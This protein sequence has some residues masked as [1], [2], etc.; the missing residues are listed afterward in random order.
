MPTEAPDAYLAPYR[1]AHEGHGSSFGVTLWASPRSQRRRFEVLTHMVFL[2][3]KRVLAAGCSRGDLA[4]FLL[5]CGIR[6]GRYIG[7]DGLASVIAY[8]QSRGLPR[9]QFHCG[10][11]L[12]QP[13]LLAIGQP[14]VIVISGTLN[15]MDFDTA[16]RVLEAAWAAAGESLIFNFLSD[17]AGP[18]APPQT[19]PARRHDTLRLLDWATRRTCSVQFRQDYFKHGHDATILMRKR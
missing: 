15:T 19:L 11:F 14:Q 2:A 17:R 5:R 6:Y 12:A 16:M 3:G 10:D 8:A 9:A 18:G 13:E 1:D 4:A 7:V